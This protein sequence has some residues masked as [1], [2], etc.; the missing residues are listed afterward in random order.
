MHRYGTAGRTTAESWSTGRP[1]LLMPGLASSTWTAADSAEYADFASTYTTGTSNRPRYIIEH[2]GTTG[3]EIDQYNLDNYGSGVGGGEV[4]LF[5]I[6]VRGVG[7][8]NAAPVFLQSTYGK[9]L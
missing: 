4:E 2:F 5:R 8:N 7:A 3:T 1:G 9:I 6:T